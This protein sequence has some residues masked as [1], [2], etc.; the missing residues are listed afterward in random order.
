[1]DQE[2]AG[3]TPRFFLATPI[4]GEEQTQ[5]EIYS[6][7]D[8]VMSRLPVRE[9]SEASRSNGLEDQSAAREVKPR[10]FSRRKDVEEEIVL[11]AHQKEQKGSL[12]WTPWWGMHRRTWIIRHLWVKT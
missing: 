6:V 8:S 3:S 5:A 12:L 9:P 4:A 7:K 10:I 1:M 11:D 2:D